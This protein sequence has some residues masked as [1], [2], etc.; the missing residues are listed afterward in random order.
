V[1]NILVALSKTGSFG[2]DFPTTVF[3]PCLSIS[4]T[5][6]I[7]VRRLCVLTG[8]GA[9]SVAEIKEMTGIALN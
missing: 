2:L 9:S 6:L 3:K 5:A 7:T 4:T 1:I 8:E